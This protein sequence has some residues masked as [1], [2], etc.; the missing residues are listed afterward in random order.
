[1]DIIIDLIDKYNQLP[2]TLKPAILTATATLVGAFVGACFAQFFSHILTLR[3]EKKNALRLNYQKLYSPVLLKVYAYYDISTHFRRGHD[4]LPGASEEKIL[5]EIIEHI[6]ENLM[7][8]TPKLISSYHQLYKYNYE[9]D[10]TGFRKDYYT[11]KLLEHFLDEISKYDIFDKDNLKKVRRYRN[12]YLIWKILTDANDSMYFALEVL[13]YDFYFNKKLL[14]KRNK[15]RRLEFYFDKFSPMKKCFKYRFSKDKAI[16]SQVE[17]IRL[18]NFIVRTFA[19]SQENKNELRASYKD[20]IENFDS[21]EM[22][23]LLKL[24]ESESAAGEMLN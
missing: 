8:A 1:M 17:A 21:W 10:A 5:E 7:Y 18:F 22:D 14:E 11:L 15:Y 6:G 9:D 20:V 4:V 12:L 24:A 19:S 23:R 3:R 13:R 16:D 2:N